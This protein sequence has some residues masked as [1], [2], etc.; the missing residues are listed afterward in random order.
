MDIIEY[1][2]TVLSNLVVIPSAVLCLAPMKN[3]FRYSR[4]KAIICMVIVFGVLIPVG[5]FLQFRFSLDANVVLI[6]M[7]VIFF[8]A[9]HLCHKVH[10][11]KSAAIF[12]YVC[13]VMS[14]FANTSNGIDA[15]INPEANALI[16]T[17]RKNHLCDIPALWSGSRFTYN[18][19]DR[20][21]LH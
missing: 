11:A 16:V 2:F 15:L 17:P 18:F 4:K 14:V 6:P 21:L 10:I 13:A 7:L 9:Y 20:K 19:G 5:A 3:Q 12:A 8:I 1:L